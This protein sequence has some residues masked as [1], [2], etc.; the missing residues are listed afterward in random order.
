[1]FSGHI[2]VAIFAEEDSPLLGLRYRILQYLLRRTV[3]YL[4]SGTEFYNI[5]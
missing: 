2:V 1:M 4:A 3:L 5:F